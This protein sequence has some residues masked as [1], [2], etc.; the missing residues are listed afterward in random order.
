MFT[1]QFHFNE[2]GISFQN[3]VYLL[4][5]I[6]QNSSDYTLAHVALDVATTLPH[7]YATGIVMFGSVLCWSAA[8]S[9]R[10]VRREIQNSRSL[11]PFLERDGFAQ[12]ILW[13]TEKQNLVCQLVEH[14][15]QSFGFIILVEISYAFVSIIATSFY[16]LVGVT[17]TRY[18]SLILSAFITFRNLFHLWIITYLADIITEEVYTTE[19]MFFLN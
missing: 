4:L 2:S 7:I 6:V 17:S 12:Q 16:I 5:L 10:A 11:V 1:F 15:N 9:L 14:I 3:G 8:E 13:W 19:N 18:D